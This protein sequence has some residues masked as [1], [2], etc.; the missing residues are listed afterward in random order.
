[1][2]QE[3]F[4]LLLGLLLAAAAPVSAQQPA[5]AQ[6]P[7]APAQRPAV[8]QQPA[9]APQ[10]TAAGP[11]SAQQPVGGPQ[12]APAQRQLSLD[13]QRPGQSD[14]QQHVVDSAAV[15]RQLAQA[16]A[17]QREA[18]QARTQQ[19][20][21]QLEDALATA[22]KHAPELLE[23]EATLQAARA[24]VGIARAP[25]RPQ[26]S[27]TVAYSR[28]TY[29]FARGGPTGIAAQDPFDTR[30]AYSAA[31]RATQLIYDFGQTWALRDS[32]LHAAEAEEFRKSAS[33]L[34]IAYG[35]RSSFLNAGKNRALAEVAQA[36]LSNQQRHLAQIKGFVDVGT[37]PLI[38]LAQSRTDVANAQLALLQ[39]QNNYAASVIQLSRSMGTP[40]VTSYDVSAA[41]PGEE[42]E[43]DS[44]VEALMQQAEEQRPELQ[45]FKK[46]LL[47]QED[48]LRSIK[49]QYGPTLNLVGG[50]TVQGYAFDRLAPNLSVG[51]NLTWPF[52]QGGLTDSR[53]SEAQAV[54]SQLQAQLE[55]VRQDLRVAVTQSGLSIRAARAALDV[56]G[57]LVQLAK[58]RLALAEGRYQ[59]GVGNTIELG[60][61]ELAL[62]DAQ[63]QRV[64][65]E[66]D[67]ALARALLHRTLGRP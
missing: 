55:I 59:A 57:E 46:Q 22:E 24:R 49:G 60:D 5:N 38:D 13:S 37:R 66:Y 67:L 42:S 48:N 39:A 31:L 65:A 61:A 32:A 30:N 9:N 16:E 40:E 41:L 47:A 50:A 8:G 7:A 33:M 27:A 63:T 35:V 17:Q 6:Q 19:R 56:A 36:T 51:A 54:T 23:A 58:D 20:V 29:N 45:A 25:L 14:A 43:E 62:R 1:M 15:Q 12:S 28:E 64:S 3:R 52:Y 34:E 21:L 44:A 11:G 4:T 18:D 26:L 2:T 10:P 53:V